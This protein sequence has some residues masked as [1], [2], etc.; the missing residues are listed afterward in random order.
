MDDGT[1]SL[2]NPLICAGQMA[3][4]SSAENNLATMVG[5][6]AA[7]RLFPLCAAPAH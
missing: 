2:D 1:G 6:Q 3:A 7:G 5:A 4:A